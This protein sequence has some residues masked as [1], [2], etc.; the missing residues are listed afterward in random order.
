MTLNDIASFACETTG[1]ISSEALEYAKKAVRLKY[2]TLYD[3]HNWREAQRLIDGKPLDPILNGV[4]FLPYDAE[5][6]IFCSLSYDAQ[7]YVRL[8]YR[9]R[10]WIERFATPA[11]TL[12]GN[13]PWFYRAENLAWPYF[14][15]GRFTFVTTD[16]SS[17]SVYISGRDSNDFPISEAFN[18][19]GINNPDGSVSAASISSVNSYKLVTALSKGVTETPLS[20]SAENPS[21]AIS[22]QMPQAL[23]ELV[24]TQIVLTP[25]PIFYATD[26]SPLSLYVRIQVKLKPDPLSNDYSVPRISHV[27]DALISFTTSALYRRLQ[28]IGKAQ[29]SEQEAMEHLRAA[30]NVEKDQAEWRQQVVPILYESGDYLSGGYAAASSTNPFG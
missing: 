16:K 29:A 26:G 9:E 24:F 4:V 18:L 7:S 14:S 19:Q 10:D 5:E 6:V 2:A 15:P 20:I 25:P 21:G 11:F 22:V 17:F 27:W 8:T 28:Q 13:S 23:T 30:I 12:P 3:A 1:D